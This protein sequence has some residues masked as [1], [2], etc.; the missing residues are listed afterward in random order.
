MLSER[1]VELIKR[2][3]ETYNRFHGAEAVARVVKI[4][5]NKIYVTFE[6][7][8]CIACGADEYVLDLKYELEDTLGCSV[9]L[10]LMDLSKL[11]EAFAHAIFKID[12]ET[13]KKEK[14]RDAALE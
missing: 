3:V 14:M 4:E 13:C 2:A 11:D 8:F 7:T 9:E 6:G 1:I 12:I 10:D 5:Q